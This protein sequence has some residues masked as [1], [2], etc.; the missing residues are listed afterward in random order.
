MP[1]NAKCS[2]GHIGNHREALGVSPAPPR[3]LRLVG[4]TGSIR[5]RPLAIPGSKCQVSGEQEACQLQEATGPA[6]KIVGMCF[7]LVG[8]MASISLG[9]TPVRYVVFQIVTVF[10]AQGRNF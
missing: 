7:L 10:K 6:D 3:D 9:E 5:K 8:F 4:I 2:A 1:T